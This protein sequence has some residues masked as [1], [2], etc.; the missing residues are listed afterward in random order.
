[1]LLHPAQHLPLTHLAGED[2]AQSFV[3]INIEDGMKSWAPHI[4]IHDHHLG[5]GLSEN[6]AVFHYLIFFSLAR[7]P[8]GSSRV[9]CRPSVS[10]HWTKVRSLAD[11][12]GRAE[13]L[14]P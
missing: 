11:C 6:H 14:Q 7:L 12:S 3:V 9:L 1:M 5:S 2:S 13:R 8:Q 10:D 4:T